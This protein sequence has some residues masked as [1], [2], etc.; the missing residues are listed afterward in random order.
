M[1]ERDIDYKHDEIRK[2]NVDT[3]RFR[4]GEKN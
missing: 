3:G 2:L 4:K 1:Y